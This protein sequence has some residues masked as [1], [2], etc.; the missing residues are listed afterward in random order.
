MVAKKAQ[1][2]T[3]RAPEPRSGTG[4][5]VAVVAE[6]PSVARDVAAVV[7]ATLRGD[8]CLVGN[9]H[10]VTWAVGHL[11]ALAEP[12]Q[13]RPEWRSWRRDQLPILPREWPLVVLER[14]RGQ[15][16]AVKRVLSDPAVVEVVCATD[17]GREGELIFR[18]L[19]E[20]AGCRKPVT[21]L[22]ISSLTPE[23]IREGLARRRP[24]GDFDRLADAA[25][26]RSRADWLVGMNASRAFTL[27]HGEP[28]TVGRVQTPT[29]AMLVERELAIRAFV[30]EEYLEVVATFEGETGRYRGTWFDPARA[31]DGGRRLPKDGGEAAAVVV[32]VTRGEAAVESV[33]SRTRRTPPPLLFD[34]T[35]LQRHANRRLG[36]S[37]KKTLEVAQRLYEER[38]ALTYPRTDS[39]HLTKDVAATL[40]GIVAALGPEWGCLFAEGTGAR[41]LGARFV[42]DAK[43]TDHHA[44]VPTPIVPRDLAGDEKA[45][46]EMVVR[47]LLAAWHADHVSATTA[48]V[49]AVTGGEGATPA[50]DRFRSAGTMVVEAGWKR[51]E[52]DA[53]ARKADD[54]GE[55]PELPPGLSPGQ[56]KTVVEVAPVERRTRPPKRF[57]DATLL[58]AMETAGRTLD[59]KE[60]ADAMGESGL[61][62]PATRAEILE[63]LLARGY[64]ERS[65]KALSA[66]EK[67]IRLIGLV[68]GSVKSPVLT[69]QWEARLARLQKGEGS[70]DAFLAGIE[71]DVRTIVGDAFGTPAGSGSGVQSCI[72]TKTHD[73]TPD[74]TAGVSSPGAGVAP[75]RGAGPDGSRPGARGPVPPERMGELLKGVFGFEAFRP[76]QE[77]V[78]RAVSGGRDALL[79]MPTGAGKSLCYQLPGLVRGGTTLVVSPLIALMED[80]AAKLRAIGLAAERIH[81]GRDRASSRQVCL[82]YLAG[83]LD[84]LFIAPERLSVPG[85]PEML[86]KRTPALV[87][88]DEAHCISHWGHDFRPDYRL[89]GARLP[90]LRPAPVIALTATATPRVQE[91]VA[92]QLGLSGP[93]RFIHGFRRT[94]LAVE[95]AEAPPSRRGEIVIEVLSDPTR[96]PAI[97]YT[98]TR[99]EAD[100]LADALG[101]RFRAV[102]YHAGMTARARDEA[103]ARFLDSRAEVVV[104]TIAFGMG[105]DKPDVRTVLH[106]GLPGSVEGYYQ[107][108]GR[109]GRDGL[110]SRAILLH[111]YGDIRTH[112]FFLERDYPEASVLGEVFRVL[113]ET[114]VPSEGLASLVPLDPEVLQK[115]LEKL[116]VFGG[117]VVT[118][119]GD[120]SRGTDGWRR[121]YEEQREHRKTQLL[122][123]R[124]FAEGPICRMLQLV[125]HFGD[126]EDDGRPCGVCDVCAPGEGIATRTRTTTPMEA[127]AL[128]RTLE[129]LRERDGQTTGQL[130]AE[131][132]RQFPSVD[133][134]AYEDLLGGLVRAG[135]ARI[136]DDEFEK[137]GRVIRFRRVY[138]T[139]AGSRTGVP[140][141]ARVA[142][143]PET[144]AKARKTKAAARKGAP[145]PKP[146]A[147]GR[148]SVQ[149]DV[150]AEGP[151]PG[152]PGAL[153]PLVDALRRWRLGEA[154]RHRLPAFRVLTDLTLLDIAARRPRTEAELAAI[155]GIGPARMERYGARLLE[156]VR[157]GDEDG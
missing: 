71:E 146:P 131:V 31:E 51:A 117:A 58:T 133:R 7:G 6:K 91:D 118:P 42:D 93:G 46:Y 27:A 123:M 139:G 95:V 82:D 114:P 65:G 43:V 86:A 88:V 63:T 156:I 25:R 107:E 4:G 157:A 134:R 36:W 74:P 119:E 132:S 57:T 92:A 72:V 137:D 127:A 98:P 113:K 9:G 141:D 83:K 35:E 108:I 14:A 99:R 70:L 39:R 111:S 84:F 96:R 143:P 49:T 110:P 3:G 28:L 38:K 103:Q 87:A 54:E 22:W 62:T 121:P 17:A 55:E 59:E 94:N 151:G 153:P 23:A 106:T 24:S 12:G 61:G 5:V 142:V 34:L 69:G 155:S 48:V 56:R 81:S 120:V 21:R 41:P 50:V 122:L 44:I 33:E 47:R 112:E 135:C 32:R 148:P 97:V 100:A 11:V 104:A 147:K 80:Q 124:R 126:E 15:F 64:A 89:L 79:V 1:A 53:P 125:R 85:F 138:A 30:P 78:C 75:G 45:L 128:R 116:W 19:Y 144:A 115:A 10:L 26:G 20:A 13:M 76:Y 60:L 109:A 2:G 66:T 136:E 18:Q 152:A 101:E 37:A 16:E 40:S 29:L 129:L 140:I 68:P 149:P 105:I 145:V 67:G 154:K 90:Q 130:H 77:A 102:A 8:G 73:C 52:P 150:G